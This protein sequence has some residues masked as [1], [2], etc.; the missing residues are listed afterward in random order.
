MK[1]ELNS[2]Y[3]LLSKLKPKLMSL[4]TYC[5]FYKAILC[6]KLL[7][8]EGSL[9]TI[10]HSSLIGILKH[11]NISYKSTHIG[12]KNLTCFNPKYEWIS[13]IIYP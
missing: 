8:F 6:M 7:L 1:Q 9:R 10:Y 13:H 2:K 12:S 4:Q 11:V 3:F 5:P